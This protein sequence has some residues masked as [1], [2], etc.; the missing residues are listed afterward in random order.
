MKF[1]NSTMKCG[2]L[3]PAMAMS[4]FLLAGCYNHS[5]GDHDAVAL[6]A[7]LNL[8]GLQLRSVLIVTSGQNEP[9][10]ILG[11]I[12]NTTATNLEMVLA[13]SDEELSVKIPAL[14]HVGL[15]RSPLV[16]DST[17]EPPG[18]RTDLGVRVRGQ[19][20]SLNVPVQNGTFDQYQPYIPNPEPSP[21]SS[22]ASAPA[23]SPAGRPAAGAGLPAVPGVVGEA[24]Q[25]S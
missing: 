3:V 19:S 14:G 18:A 13:D 7:D 1:K 2:R 21:A 4:A 15:D 20:A 23:P 10:R 12:F 17:Q 9:G 22:A 5:E 11:T 24:E 8:S 25:S 16:F 6:G